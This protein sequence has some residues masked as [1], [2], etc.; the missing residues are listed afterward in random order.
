MGRWAYCEILETLL[1]VYTTKLLETRYKVL[2]YNVPLLVLPRGEHD[3]RF[4]QVRPILIE[5]SWS[6]VG[7]NFWRSKFSIFESDCRNSISDWSTNWTFKDE[8]HCWLQRLRPTPTEINWSSIGN[9]LS[10]LLSDLIG[11]LRFST[12]GPSEH[13]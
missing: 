13:P 1:T 11:K 6:S 12:D 2:L 9:G 4:R 3:W 8:F 5:I 10:L 7:K